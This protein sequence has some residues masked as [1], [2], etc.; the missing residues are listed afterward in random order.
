MAPDEGKRCRVR[1][2]AEG[3]EQ[4]ERRWM[5]HHHDVDSFCHGLR[6]KA[7]RALEHSVARMAA[8]A[9]RTFCC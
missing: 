9:C 3:G 7:G 5:P 1:A 8:G 6:R 2:S 4:N